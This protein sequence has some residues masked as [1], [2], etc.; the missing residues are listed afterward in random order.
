MHG[1]DTGNLSIYVKTNQ[2]ETL[3]WRLSGDQ[4]NRWRFGQ[5]ALNSPSSYKFVIEGTVGNGSKGDIAVDDLTVMDGVCDEIIKQASP[6]CEFE[7]SMCDWDAEQGWV[8]KIRLERFETSGKMLSTYAVFLSHK[9][10][11]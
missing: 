8:L 6:D 3:V 4:G 2:S 5:T 10:L 7:E 9:V 11:M 1:S